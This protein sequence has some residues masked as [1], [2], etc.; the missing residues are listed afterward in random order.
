AK[1]STP[2]AI[3]LPESAPSLRV[4]SVAGEDVPMNPRSSYDPVDLQI[5]T[6]EAAVFEIEASN[7][8]L[9]TVVQLTLTSEMGEAPVAFESTP[10]AGL[11]E[12]STATASTLIPHGYSRFRVEA[13]W[14]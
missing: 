4:V 10:L 7:I 8:P 3:A 6:G 13:T 2:G 5:D 1:K 12:S 9:G 11:P 14:E